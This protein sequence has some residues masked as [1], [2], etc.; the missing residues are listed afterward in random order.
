MS[1]DL[2]RR[3]CALALLTAPGISLAAHLIQATPTQHD[4]G[5][6]LASIAAAPGRAELSAAVGS[7]ALLLMIP[8]VL[9]LARPL[10]ARRPLLALVGASM[11]SAGI[12]ALTALLG[13][14]PVT[15]AMASSVADREEMVALTDRYEGSLL[16]TGWVL[17]MIVGYALGPI[18]LAIGWWRI[19]APLL[20]PTALVLGLVATMAD[21]GRWPLAGG[22]LLTWLGLAAAG[23]HL[24]RT[25]AI[26]TTTAPE[27][28]APTPSR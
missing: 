19:G 16:L 23:M 1:D 6:E 17:V 7:I 11:S 9:G 20:V 5:T 18:V 8:A 4:T 12:V 13:S 10:W 27:R 24:W 14:A 22:M 28:V 2:R 15:V 25:A 26:T 21:A 3:G